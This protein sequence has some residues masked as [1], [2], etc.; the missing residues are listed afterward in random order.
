MSNERP[1]R[2]HRSSAPHREGGGKQP[3]SSY[4]GKSAQRG[5][6]PSK[7]NPNYKRETKFP[8]DPSHLVQRS[9]NDGTDGHIPVVKINSPTRSSTVF[10]KRITDVEQKTKHGDLV[11]VEV[12]G[13]EFLGYGIWN[14]RAEAAI[15]I[16]SWDI[17]PTTKDWWKPRFDDAIAL[18]KSTL[19]LEKH[20]NAY[21]IINA[22]GDALPGVMV[23]LYGGVLS[24]EAF[25]LGMYQR[26]EAIARTIAE[27]LDIQH[28]VVRPGP[29]TLDH[30][31]FLADGFSSPNAPSKVQIREHDVIFEVNPF[32]G[33]KTG[34]FCDQRDN[35]LALRDYCR[36]KTVLD[37]CSYT[38]GFAINA[39][40]AGAKEVTAVD[41][42]EDAI[43]AARRNAQLNKASIK[44]V[45]ADAFGYMRD[46][47]ANGKKFDVVIL[48]PPKLI[49]S[50]DAA[51]EGQSKY[52][53]LN[54]LAAPLV[55]SG[56]LLLTCSCSGLFSMDELTRTVRAACGDRKPQLLKRSGAAAD[57]PVALGSLESEYLK[58][59]WLRMD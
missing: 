50:R 15:R 54:K 42:D 55:N 53:D 34:F 45:H 7:S 16:L 24:L 18:R 41:L 9:L 28:W 48:D 29:A 11:R 40:Y 59:L 58:C 26:S 14:P 10:R 4:R 44:F 33:H 12:E 21:R 27:K 2:P 8:L 5:N 25:S 57:H 20:T 51:A 19:R 23:D 22:E 30:E 37:L 56:G 32:D 35:R 17:V 36:G 1:S 31:G 6:G 38:G 49:H 46:M 39:A 43:K 52:F 47:Q 3:G 13:G